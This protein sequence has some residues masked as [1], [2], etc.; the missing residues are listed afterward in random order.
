[1]IVKW[2][3]L[4]L[5][6]YNK[7]LLANSNLL[8]ILLHKF[9]DKVKQKWFYLDKLARLYIWKLEEEFVKILERKYSEHDTLSE[10][11]KFTKKGIMRIKSHENL[12]DAYEW[13]TYINSYKI[14]LD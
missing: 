6:V 3:S 5:A 10:T 14:D 13:T 4:V 1:M 12:E 8:L 11:L 9:E 7:E 2:Y